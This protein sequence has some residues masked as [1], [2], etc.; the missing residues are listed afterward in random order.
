MIVSFNNLDISSKIRAI[1]LVTTGVALIVACATIITIEFKAYRQA[2]VERILVLSNFVATNATAVLSFEDDTTARKLL[3]SVNAEAAIESATLYRSDWSVLAVYLARNYDSKHDKHLVDWAKS[4]AAGQ[5]QHFKVELDQVYVLTPIRVDLETIGYLVI[6]TTL[7]P[8]Y[9]RIYDLIIMATLVWLLVMLVVYV[10][11]HSVH[12]KISDPIQKLLEGMQLVSNRQDYSLRLQEGGDDEIGKIIKGFNHMIEQ[13]QQRDQS[14]AAHRR[15]LED[16]VEKRTQDLQAAMKDAIISKEQAEKASS[17]KSEFLATMSHEIRTPM[18][19]ILGM[20]ELLSDGRLSK[21][22]EKFVTTIRQSGRNLLKIINEIL[23]FSKIEAGR[24]ELENDDFNLSSMIEDMTSLLAER[25]YQKGIELICVLPAD[26]RLY[27]HG[28]DGKL[29]QI[30]M[31]LVGNAIKF[32]EQGEV[33]ISLGYERQDDGF[34][35]IDIEVKDTGIGIEENAQEKIFEAFSQADGS[36]A[37]K[38]GGTGLGLAITQKLIQLMGGE[39]RM[40][41]EKGQGTRFNIHLHLQEPVKEH[42]DEFKAIN[43]LKQLKVMAVEAKK[44]NRDLLQQILQNWGIQIIVAE[45][46]EQALERLSGMDEKP[47]DI[48]I[49]DSQLTDMTGLQWIESCR[50]LPGFAQVPMIMIGTRADEAELRRLRDNKI[51]FLNKPLIHSDLYN[52]LLQMSGHSKASDQMAI[53]ISRTPKTGKHVLLAEDN[54]VNQE[55]VLNLLEMAGHRMDLANNGLEAVELFQQQRFDLVLMDCQMP[56]MDGFEA[57][58]KIRQITSQ[59]GAQVPIIALTANAMSGD[60]EQCIAAGMNDYLSKPFTMADF[61]TMMD[62]WLPF[63]QSP[64]LADTSDKTVEI[65]SL[66]LMDEPQVLDQQVLNRL[67]MM[68]RPGAPSIL[69]KVIDIYLQNSPAL[70][71]D[72][73]TAVFNK[74]AVALTRAA[75]SLKSSSANLGASRLS[76]LCK[77]LE[78]MGRAQALKGSDEILVQMLDDSDQVMAALKAELNKLRHQQTVAG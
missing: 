17:A 72:I 6:E 20:A 71:D 34:L 32:T 43:E 3:E 21:K 52:A 53:D 70:I 68:Q 77:S 36:M 13:V 27:V 51:S 48:I 61:N 28:D 29:R 33:V 37:R 1:V 59:G 30:L 19:G 5:R 73:R 66:Q 49:L 76:E 4:A 55:L 2:M 75:H 18:N 69:Q 40:N 39:L 62:K 56:E 42:T 25:A 16:T 7:T 38:Y 74:D 54:P 65:K 64:Q 57:T 58:A 12:R 11:S 47:F 31:N 41:S 35:S 78:Q 9:S 10:I 15:E 44:T 14:L 46:G 26:E 8:I 45:T 63:E 67:R 60:R 23:D 24:M 50:R 22:Q